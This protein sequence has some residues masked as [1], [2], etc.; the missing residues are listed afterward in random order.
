PRHGGHAA[1]GVVRPAP[2]SANWSG[3]RTPGV[4]DARRPARTQT[5]GNSPPAAVR[6]HRHVRVARDTGVA[7]LPAHAAAPAGYAEAHPLPPG[8]LVMSCGPAPEI[9][10]A[11]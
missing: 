1:G 8:P 10:P 5:L 7:L 11:C 4:L 6:Q 9:Q 2:H 3:P